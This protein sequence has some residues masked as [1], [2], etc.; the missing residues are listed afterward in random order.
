MPSSNPPESPIPQ[1]QAT[2]Q[3]RSWRSLLWSFLGTIARWLRRMV[4]RTIHCLHQTPEE[5]PSVWDTLLT[6]PARLLIVIGAFVV[7]VVWEDTPIGIQL[8]W[9]L[10]YGL[11]AAVSI[12]TSFW[13]WILLINVAVAVLW[14]ALSWTAPANANA[15]ASAGWTFRDIV[16]W[17]NRQVGHI[18]ALAAWVAIAFVLRPRLC[19]QAPL[20]AAV[21]FWG[22]PIINA[23]ARWD[24]MGGSAARRSRAALMMERRSLI[25]LASLLG[26]SIL[27]VQA[28]YQF[29]AIF[30]LLLTVVPGL[31]L[32]YIRFRRRKYLERRSVKDAAIVDRARGVTDAEF[33]SGENRTKDFRDF[34]MSRARMQASIAP[35][36]DLFGPL[37]VVSLFVAITMLSLW[38]RHRMAVDARSDEDGQS[39][40]EDA[41]VPEP[42]GPVSPTVALFI[43]SD[44]QLHELGGM[45]FPGQM[46]VADR[47]VPVA[48]RPIELDILSTAAV[49]RY[50][51][52]Y[53]QLSKERQSAGL[54]PLLWTHLGDFADLSCFGE[55]DRMMNLLKG[56]GQHGR[57]LAGI[58]PGNHDSNFTGNFSWSPYW[59]AACD[60]RASKDASR[61]EIVRMDKAA[62]DR[63]IEQT[64]RAYLVNAEGTQ[65]LFGWAPS[66]FF[67]NSL[68]SR[69]TVSRL[70]TVKVDNRGRE[71][72]VVGVFIDTSDRLSRNFGIAGSFG[73]FSERQQRAILEQVNKERT[74]VATDPWGDPWFVVFGHHPYNEMTGGSQ[75]AL[76]GLITGLDSPSGNCSA[77]DDDCRGPR[78]MA[79]ITAHTHI[80]ESHRHCV[81]QRLVREIVVG[82]VID[83]PQQASILEIGVDARGRGAVRLSTLPTVARSGLTCST[84]HTIDAGTCRQM[85]ATL[86]NAPDCQEL[87]VGADAG[88]EAGASC[89]SLERPL[90]TDEQVQGL[91]RHGGPQDPDDLKRSEE[92]RARALLR[93]IC[94]PIP[95]RPAPPA[96]AHRETLLD[97]EAYA[98]IVE[99]VA[100]DGNRQPEV[101][102]LAWAAAAVQAHKA[103]G[104]KMADA[105]RCAFDDPTLPA[106]QVTV[107]AREDV[108]C[109]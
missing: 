101:T 2:H 43:L 24:F 91:V 1:Q 44:T 29:W 67:G 70:G 84:A 103:A 40:P 11:L 38:Q 12:V 64:S 55:M 6:W 79:L 35:V 48:R 36:A 37:L 13:F 47:L 72:G 22:P 51:T 104:M 90:S 86:A 98:P 50:Q 93:C 66:A 96:C 106:A 4:V 100:R 5:E 19:V 46:E 42:G 54:S 94:R 75:K 16:T 18:E 34:R 28:P 53:E 7:G 14:L 21:I 56:Y 68:L 73:T 87:I 81:D 97:G 80:A 10:Q 65:A 33:A 89:E 41:C 30:P 59:D 71:R 62:S 107:A 85:M 105:I 32:R 92:K 63:S 26:L 27:V 69:F 78:V 39:P 23:L 15:D 82:S 77:G 108:T 17:A 83:P 95:N 102:C 49:V 9:A 3:S 99:A 61:A 57:L 76:N 31:S 8:G 74:G 109:H 20:L 25:Y 60:S 52:V 88:Q 58:A 45:R